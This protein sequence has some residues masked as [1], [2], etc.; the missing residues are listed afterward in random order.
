MKFYVA[1]KFQDRKNVRKLMDKIQ[2]LGHTIT[3]DWTIDEESDD[4]YPIV[5]TLRDTWGVQIC[6]TY[7][8]RFIKK[9]RYRGALVEFG[10][11]LGLGKRI[12][13]I[14][15]EADGCIFSNHPNVQRFDNEQEFLGYVEKV[16]R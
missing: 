9:N 16:L 13:F 12:C 15:H 3:Y 14:G 4:G 1:G 2:D 10:I 11:A 6:D 8:G 7:V 5:N